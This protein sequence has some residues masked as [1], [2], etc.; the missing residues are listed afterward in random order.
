MTPEERKELEKKIK[1]TKKMILITK[2]LVNRV[3]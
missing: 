1:K 3:L 2:D